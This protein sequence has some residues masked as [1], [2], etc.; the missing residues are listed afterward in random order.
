MNASRRTFL[1]AGGTALAAMRAAGAND[2]IRVGLIG[3]GGR[4][5]DHMKELARLKDL[6]V[7]IT[8]LCDVWKVNRERAEGII[9]KNFG[10]KPR[11]TTNYQE[12]LGWKDLDAVVIATPD[13]THPIIL[14]AALDAGKDVYVEKPFAT[15]FVDGKAAYLK[16][17]ASR[18]VVAVGTQRRSDGQF[19][20]AATRVQR[21]D[22]GKITRIEFCNNFQ[23][24]RW[25][26]PVDNVRAEDIDWKS[27]QMGRITRGFDAHLFREWQLHEE[28]TNGIAGLWMC[29]FIDLIPW[30]TGDPYPAGAVTSGGVYLWKDGR[31]TSDVFYTLL[32]YPKEFIVL[33][34]MSLTNSAG[35]RNIWFGSKGTLD[36]DKFTFTGAGSRMPDRLQGEV[37]VE[38]ETT[39]S[40][41]QNFL[42]CIRSRGK[43]RADYQAGFS[44]AVALL[45]SAEALQHGRRMRFDAAKLEIV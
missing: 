15:T 14:Q 44:H 4:G 38:P 39:N 31:K 25:Q 34:E 40:H 24:A 30:Y 42:E 23:E 17:K 3:A 1:T 28:T 12:L 2:R 20:A 18:Q 32:D 35:N 19:M 26:R 33:F 8:G 36:C 11:S 6:N 13:F 10:A 21:G 5:G 16:A 22:L 45:L 29:H 37:K 7:A 43:P 41:M 27:F 9:E